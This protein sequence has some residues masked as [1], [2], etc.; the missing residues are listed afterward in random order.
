MKVRGVKLALFKHATLTT[1]MSA[2]NDFTAGKA[3][4]SGNSG[5]VAYAAGDV[6][7]RDLIGDPQYWHD[8]TAGH[9]ALWYKEG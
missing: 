6:G 8:G 7:E 5:T 3:V 2:V 4:T 9:V 1:L